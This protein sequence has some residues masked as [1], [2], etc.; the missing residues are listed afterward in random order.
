MRWI[1]AKGAVPK[2]VLAR[3]SYFRSAKRMPVAGYA[4]EAQ[5]LRILLLRSTSYSL[6]HSSSC[7]L[8]A[9]D[10][11]TWAAQQTRFAGGAIALVAG[12]FQLNSRL[13]TRV[14]IG[15][16]RWLGR[17]YLLAVV[18]G[19]GAG[20]AL[21][22]HAFG[23][24]TARAAF[25]LLAVC[26]TGSTLNAYRH[27]RQGNLRAHRSWMIRSYALTLAAVTLRM[28]LTLEPTGR[29]SDASG[30]SCNCMAL[31]G[32]QPGDRRMVRPVPTLFRDV[33]CQLIQAEAAAWLGQSINRRREGHL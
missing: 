25:G 10:A 30:L 5:A 14:F 15:A 18:S 29:H 3:C 20:F 33:A 19:G 16:H 27:I 13:R 28:Y 2:Y 7:T 23:G 31:L 24:L 11:S 4:L 17:L 32:S 12:A 9:G 26:W 6:C 21:A 8:D 22:Q 1:I